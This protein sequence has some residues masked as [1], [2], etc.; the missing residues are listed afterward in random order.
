MSCRRVEKGL[1]L[2]ALLALASV[3]PAALAARPVERPAAVSLPAVLHEWGEWWA[4]LLRGPGATE[5]LDDEAMSLGTSG[6]VPHERGGA[7]AVGRCAR[8]RAALAPQ[9]PEGKK[10]Q[11]S[12]DCTDAGPGFDP[13]G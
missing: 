8:E 1:A 4:G 13:E 5:G 9:G 11:C 6:N 12:G 10:S 7:R 3:S 2:V